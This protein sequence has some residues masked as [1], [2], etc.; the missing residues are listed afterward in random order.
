MRV[1]LA[2]CIELL[3]GGLLLAACS[4]STG[5]EVEMLRVVPDEFVISLVADGELRG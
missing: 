3:M 4:G 1:P 5:D 2:C